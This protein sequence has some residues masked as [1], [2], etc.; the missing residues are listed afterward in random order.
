VQWN[1]GKEWWSANDIDENISMWKRHGQCCM[2][3]GRGKVW[4]LILWII[5]HIVGLEP[6]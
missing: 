6:M 3:N 2:C 4:V 1:V 5:A